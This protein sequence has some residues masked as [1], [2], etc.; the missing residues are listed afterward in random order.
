MVMTGQGSLFDA[1]PVEPKSPPI[2]EVDFRRVQGVFEY[3]CEVFDKRSDTILDEKRRKAINRALNLWTLDT[4]KL[5]ILGCSLTAWNMGQNPSSKKYTDITLILRDAEHV[6]RFSETAM[7]SLEA[8]K[9]H[10][11]WL[12]E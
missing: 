9:R 11:E 1:G 3:W 4:I 8:N 6:D 2:K 7:V 12:N 5:A 10:Q